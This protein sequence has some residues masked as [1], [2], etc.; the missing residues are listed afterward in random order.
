MNNNFYKLFLLNKIR[1]L[2]KLRMINKNKNRIV[3]TN[4]IINKN[5][6][7]NI[8]NNKNKINKIKINKK[9]PLDIYFFHNKY[10]HFQKNIIN[11]K[12]LDIGFII[13]RHVNSEITNTYWIKS[14]NCVRK[15]YPENKI[16]IIDDNSNEKFLTSINL[17]NTVII[18]SE[19][20]ARGELLP[21]YYYLKN[22]LFDK[23]VIIHDSVFINRYI[24]FDVEDYKLLWSFDSPRS[25]KFQELIPKI[26]N[27]F[28]D[29]S[30]I[31]FYKNNNS[32]KGCFGGMTVITHDYL[33]FI[34]SKY[35]LDKLLHYITN[36]TRRMCFERILGCI[37]Q[38]YKPASSLLDNIHHYC[39]WGIKI[40][41]IN[42]PNIK[43]LPLIKVWTGR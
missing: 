43:K 12:N 9:P 7:K 21:Y 32:W 8:K 37:L 33:S 23:A 22:K 34:N 20:P 24:D 28:N 26:L 40:N 11:T 15:F 17:Y 18:N 1:A 38:F 6:N 2:H 27:I 31:N 5:L 30:L 14:Y 36:R 25:C 29:P 42:L 39:P 3:Y 41:Q 35:K 19:F 13:L 10:L 4:N 16:I